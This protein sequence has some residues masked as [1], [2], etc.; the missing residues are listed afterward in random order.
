MK[1]FDTLLAQPLAESKATHLKRRFRLGLVC[2]DFSQPFSLMRV[3]GPF[4]QMASE[5]PNLQLVY[6]NRD[7]AGRPELTWDWLLRCDAVFYYEVMGDAHVHHMAL[8]RM[9]GKP[10]W[11]EFVDDP[12]SVR[13]N[14]PGFPGWHDH[15]IVKDNIAAAVNVAH[16]VTVTSEPLREVFK[17][18]LA[19]KNGNGDKFLVVP[20]AA[21]WPPVDLPRQ[22]A[23]SWRGLGS[24]IEDTDSVLE[25][26]ASVAAEYAG[27]DW[28]LLGEPSRG[29]IKALRSATQEKEEGTRVKVSPFWPSPFEMIRA[30]SGQ[31]PFLHLTPL[32]ENE[33]N[34]GKSHLAWLEASAIGA[35]VIA[36]SFLTEWRQPGVIPY[37][38]GSL[39]TGDGQTFREVLAREMNRFDSGKPHPAVAEA[40]AAIYPA[41]T[42]P[43]MN[44]RRWA[45][46]KR[47]AG[48]M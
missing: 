18:Q 21:L 32:A 23:V 31:S 30:W 7:A 37:R 19:L 40:R 26:L 17:R 13:P 42:L 25:A 20:E 6:P 27:W 2:P 24:H 22:R 35:A 34:A 10:V 33:F 38:S 5:N 48:E 36:P 28:V 46:L 1:E 11:A 4:E 47:L 41:R 8:A 14:N 16:V 9:M 45:I 39:V 29:L 12:F 43:A 44:R 3:A 15:E